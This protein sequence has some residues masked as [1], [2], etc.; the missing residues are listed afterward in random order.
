MT[1]EELERAVARYQAL[2]VWRKRE[3][4]QQRAAEAG[5]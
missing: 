2:P 1:A 4:H 3:L 5:A